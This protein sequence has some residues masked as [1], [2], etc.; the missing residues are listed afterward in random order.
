V[1]F[2]RADQSDVRTGRAEGAYDAGFQI[3]GVDAL[4][5][6]LRARDADI[7]DGPDTRVY[8]QRE[9]VV[10]DCNGLILCFAESTSGQVT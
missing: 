5:A 8:E 10:K 2:N 7:L 9:L 1:F 4:A 3:I 6:E